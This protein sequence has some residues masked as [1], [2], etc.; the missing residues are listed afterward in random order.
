MKYAA[1]RV[2]TV[3][4]FAIAA[5]RSVVAVIDWIDSLC[6]LAEITSISDKVGILI[7]K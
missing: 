1:G 3:E 2:A 5:R 4:Q 6:R 7:L